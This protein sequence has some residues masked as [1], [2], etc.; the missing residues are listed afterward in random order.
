VSVVCRAS[1]HY[2]CGWWS[3]C[4]QIPPIPRRCGSSFTATKR[5][6]R[7]IASAAMTSRRPCRLP[8]GLVSQAKKLDEA[9]RGMTRKENACAE[10][11]P[12]QAAAA[13]A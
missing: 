5:N 4:R 10:G 6:E 12:T 2:D 9:S 8:R 11:L 3:S 1:Y 7:S 13:P